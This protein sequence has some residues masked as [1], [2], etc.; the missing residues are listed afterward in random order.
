MGSSTD[1][2]SEGLRRLV[3]NAVYWGLAMEVPEKA[4]VFF[5]GTYEPTM[6]GFNLYKKG[7]K[8]SDHRLPE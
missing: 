3:T 4:D 8:P 7:V 6:Y 1:F 2:K 5:V